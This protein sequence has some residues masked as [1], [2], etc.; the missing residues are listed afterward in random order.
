LRKCAAIAEADSAADAAT[1]AGQNN[2]AYAN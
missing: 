2:A 1:I